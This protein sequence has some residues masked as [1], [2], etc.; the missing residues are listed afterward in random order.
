MQNIQCHLLRKQ[1]GHILVKRFCANL[2]IL[3]SFARIRI[4]SYDT[5]DLVSGRAI[6]NVCKNRGFFLFCLIGVL[7]TRFG[8]YR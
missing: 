2:V 7:A 6:T 5:A 3:T 1:R 4:D 8:M